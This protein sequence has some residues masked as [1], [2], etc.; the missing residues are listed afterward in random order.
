MERPRDDYKA[1]G[2]NVRLATRDKLFGGQVSRLQVAELVGACCASPA[3][4]ANKVLEVVAETTAPALGYDDL[5][6][7]HPAG[8]WGRG[9][10]GRGGGGRGG[11]GAWMGVR[12]TE[13]LGMR[14]GSGAMGLTLT[15]QMLVGASLSFSSDALLMFLFC[16]CCSCCCCCCCCRGKPGGARG[17]ARGPGGGGGAGGGG[18]PADCRRRAAPGSHP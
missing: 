5:L 10:A 6:V 4:A 7:Q 18:A 9:R 13:W 15:Q 11:R 2:H 14:G 17:G 8:G 12:P 3:L 16:C 1:T